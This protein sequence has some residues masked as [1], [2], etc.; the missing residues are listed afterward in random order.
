MK[1]TTKA[2][3]ALIREYILGCITSDEKELTTDVDK[4]LYVLECFRSEFG[5][6]IPRKGELRAF[7][8]YLSGLPSCMTVA[9]YNCEILDLATAWGADVSTEKKEDKII[10]GYWL[11]MANKFFKFARRL[12]L[13]D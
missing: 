8:E 1:M 12:K 10:E 6:E 3:D 5:H 11:F 2:K 9:F 7:A 13:V 4:F